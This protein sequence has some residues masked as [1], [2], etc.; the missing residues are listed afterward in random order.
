MSFWIVPVSCLRRNP[1]LFGS[2]DVERHH[3]EHRTVH[4]HG[5][6]HSIERNAVEQ[7]P[8]VEN[9][10]DRHTCHPHVSEHSWV[11]RVVTPVGGQIEGDGETPLPRL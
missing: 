4:G 7:N 11:I 5:D 1:L 9:G 6:T 8:H 3:R 10:V 2:H